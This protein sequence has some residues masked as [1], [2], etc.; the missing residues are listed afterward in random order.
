MKE[1]CTKCNFMQ[2]ERGNLI[3]GA[4]MDY[5]KMAVRMTT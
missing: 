4:Y 2:S 5:L 1:A 3:D